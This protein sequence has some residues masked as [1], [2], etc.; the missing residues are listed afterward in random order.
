MIEKDE[1]QDITDQVIA[2]LEGMN[3]KELDEFLDYCRHNSL[4]IAVE[5]DLKHAED[6]DAATDEKHS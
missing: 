2:D 5:S 1:E 4:N 6:K 3:G